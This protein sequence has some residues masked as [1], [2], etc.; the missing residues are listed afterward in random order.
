MPNRDYESQLDKP[1]AAATPG[2]RGV[3]AV[4]RS[5]PSDL[6]SPSGTDFNQTFRQNNPYSPSGTNFSTT[7]AATNTGL[8]PS[9][10]RNVLTQNPNYQG[11]LTSAT[12]RSRDFNAFAG[13]TTPPPTPGD[14]DDTFF[15]GPT[16]TPT[17]TPRPSL[18]FFRNRRSNSYSPL[19]ARDFERYGAG[20]DFGLT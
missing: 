8:A 11:S 13:K 9:V 1:E 19:T 15:G 3:T 16:P 18:A 4:G 14:I 17:P 12:G 5:G 20:A 10:S 2:G 7:F 6:S